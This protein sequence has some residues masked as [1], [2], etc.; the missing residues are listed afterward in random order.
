MTPI[1]GINVAC[2]TPHAKQAHTVDL[3]ATLELVDFL[4]GA[5]AQGLALLGST[6]EFAALSDDDRI[7]LVYLATKRSRVPVLAGVGHASLDGAVALAREAI[8]AGVA[9][10]LLMPP[11]FFR[12]AQPEVREFYLHFAAQVGGNVP[13]YL[14]NIPFFT[15]EI[16]CDTALDLLSRGLFA[17]IKDSSGSVDYFERLQASPDRDF[18]TLLAGNDVIFTRAR[19]GG[20][21]GV[22][23]GVACAVPELM[24]ALDRAIAGGPKS[25]VERLDAKLQEFIAWLDRFPTPVGVKAA[26]AAR[27]IKVGPYLTPLSIDAQRQLAE[28]HEWFLGWLP[29]LRRGAAGA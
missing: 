23:S 28:F 21:D 12:Y 18:F 2:I 1:R 9:G 19:A 22:V 5:G 7:R 20:A 10:L 14:Y 8:G 13:I 29:G 27:G 24:L 25:E 26:V 17:G 16:A 11:L 3:G 4:C 6:G 15:T